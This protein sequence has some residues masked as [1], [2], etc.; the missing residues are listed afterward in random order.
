[1]SES[2]CPD[3][4]LHL[5]RYLGPCNDALEGVV[6]SSVHHPVS[7]VKSVHCQ[8][9]PSGLHRAI[10]TDSGRPIGDRRTEI[11]KRLEST[12]N[13]EGQAGEKKPDSDRRVAC[14]FFSMQLNDE[15]GVIHATCRRCDK[16]VILYDR[17]LYWGVKR[18]S[19]VP[20]EVYPYKCTC[21]SH[22]FEIAMGFEYPADILDEN[23]LN[24]ITVAVRCASCNEIAVVFDDEAT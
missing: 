9:A 12:R 8:C 5:Q 23:D 18:K 1:M 20:P 4:P 22:A 14:R 15:E 21:G 11:R 13:A 7:I 10:R 6:R 3:G 19:N 24:T 16:R 17:A 2:S